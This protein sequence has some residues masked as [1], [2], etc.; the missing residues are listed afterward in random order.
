MFFRLVGTGVIILMVVISIVFMMSIGRAKRSSI[1][2]SQPA[3]EF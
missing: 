1:G 3:A 2:T